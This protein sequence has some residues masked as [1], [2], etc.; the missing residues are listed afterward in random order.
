MA[1]TPL[2]ISMSHSVIY[3]A[4]RMACKYTGVAD[5]PAYSETKTYY[6]LRTTCHQCNGEQKILMVTE[7]NSE[8]FV[9]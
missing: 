5:H 3:L 4:S 8:R 6:K 9:S 7:L 1:E 2:A